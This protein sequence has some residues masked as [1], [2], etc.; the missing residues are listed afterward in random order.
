[1]GPES[2]LVCASRRSLT[3]GRP[4][5]PSS[6]LERLQR[7]ASATRPGRV[8]PVCGTLWGVWHVLYPKKRETEMGLSVSLASLDS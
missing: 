7:A 2:A 4:K 8:P 6:R 1:M 3:V 5:C